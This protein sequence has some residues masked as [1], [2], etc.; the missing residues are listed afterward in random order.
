V[1]ANDARVVAK[2]TTDQN[3]IDVE[4]RDV[5]SAPRA[6]PA[7]PTADDE[8]RNHRTHGT[9]RRKASGARSRPVH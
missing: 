8:H 7:C 9:Q 2:A 4:A 3:V 6:G 1:A 5:T